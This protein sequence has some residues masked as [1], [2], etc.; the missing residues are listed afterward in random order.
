MPCR[1]LQTLEETFSGRRNVQDHN[2]LGK[3][4]VFLLPSSEGRTPPFLCYLLSPPYYMV[5][6]IFPS[7]ILQSGIFVK[8]SPLTH[9]ERLITSAIPELL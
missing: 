4:S 7:V 1:F 2:L 8:A 5:Q 6:T 9:L 3:A